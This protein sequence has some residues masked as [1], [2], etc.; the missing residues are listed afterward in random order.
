MHFCKLIRRKVY[1]NNTTNSIPKVNGKE[2]ELYLRFAAQDHSKLEE[3]TEFEH[4]KNTGRI[5]QWVIN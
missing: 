1:K 3:A 2:K 4:S 5:T